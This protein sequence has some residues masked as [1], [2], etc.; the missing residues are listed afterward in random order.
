MNRPGVTA[1]RGAAVPK[2][3]TV[4]RLLDRFYPVLEDGQRFRDG[5]SPFY[6]WLLSSLDGGSRVLNVGAGPMPEPG[7]RMRGLVGHLVGVDIDPV[8]MTNED[9]DEAQVIDGVRLPYEDNLFDAVYS[10]W[11]M[12]HVEQPELLLREIHRVLK[13]GAS[14]WLRTTNLHHY[15][16]A[17]AA[18]TPHW[19][20][21][22]ALGKAG[23]ERADGGPW[24]TYY[25]SNTPAR[26]R[27][28]LLRAGFATCQ[29]D[30]LEPNPTYLTFNSLTFLIGVGYERLVNVSARLGGLRLIVLAKATKLPCEGAAGHPCVALRVQRTRNADLIAECAGWISR[31]GPHQPSTG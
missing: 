29:I 17:I 5:N 22:W 27:A 20:H 19:F 13:P 28:Q 15:V 21:T 14:Y 9:L 25:R 2:S 16:T 24:R 31:R 1:V 30:T 10:D 6:A 7:R 3:R 23:V 18:V 12:E 4:A 11:T 8:V 26:L